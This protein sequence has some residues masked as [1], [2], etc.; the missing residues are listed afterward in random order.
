MDHRVKRLACALGVVSVALAAMLCVA[1][2]ST[3]QNSPGSGSS[4]QPV[5]PNA[6]Q[7]YGGGYGGYE[8]SP[9]TVAGSAMQGMASLAQAA[10]SYNL[11]TSAAAVNMTQARK[12]D[13][14]NYSTG[15]NTFFET[16]RVNKEARLA[17]AGPRLTEAQI[18]RIAHESAPKP[19]SPRQLDPVSGR[20]F[21]P[22][23]LQAD[24]FQEQRTVLEQAFSLRSQK[25]TLQLEEAQQVKRTTQALLTDLRE[26]VQDADPMAY[27]EAKRFVESLAYEARKPV[28]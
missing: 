12:Q 3:A 14:E 24:R 19:L 9:G 11:S 20:I 27:M 10:G 22:L 17:E 6:Q 25:G 13:L 21:W 16:R 28:A 1:S 23:M 26:L 2:M 7:V 5:V 8:S 15:V 18:V 4:Y